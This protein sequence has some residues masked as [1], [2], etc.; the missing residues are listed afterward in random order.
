MSLVNED[1][2][3]ALGAM[4]VVKVG[5]TGVQIILGA[6]AQFIANLLEQPSSEFAPA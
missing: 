4:G 1:A 6:K 2:I 5:N 3:K